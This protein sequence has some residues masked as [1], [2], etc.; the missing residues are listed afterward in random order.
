MNI[1]KYITIGL[2]FIGMTTLVGCKKEDK[3]NKNLW[4]NGGEWNISEVKFTTMNSA[5]QS[6]SGTIYDYGTFKFEKDG[7][8]TRTINAD[9]QTFTHLFSYTNTETE[10]VITLKSG[11]DVT[12]GEKEKYK[13]TWKKDNIELY[14]YTSWEDEFGNAYHED[15]ITLKKKK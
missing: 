6:D 3:I 12:P 10:L 7:T 1:V 15:F 5:G 11:P 4:K 9:G 8:G 14:I 13:M 2:L